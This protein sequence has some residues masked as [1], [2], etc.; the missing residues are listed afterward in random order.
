MS[1]KRCNAPVLGR[2]GMATFRPL[3]R[4]DNVLKSGTAQSSPT[5]LNRLAT[6]PVVCRNGSPNSAF[7]VRHARIAASEKVADRPRLPDGAPNHCV[8]GSNQI[9]NEPRCLSAALAIGLEP[10]APQWRDKSASSSCDSSEVGVCSC[11]PTNILESH[12][13]SLEI[14]ATEPQRRRRY[15]GKGRGRSRPEP[16]VR[17]LRGGWWSGWSA[18]GTGGQR[19]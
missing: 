8:S 4:R 12:K 18:G 11:T 1:I 7:S 14:C 5:S 2:Y 19:R 16:H 15:R 17:W 9:S 6:S 13:G 10:M 3:G